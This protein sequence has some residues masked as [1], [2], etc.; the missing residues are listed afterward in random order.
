[1]I[2]IMLMLVAAMASA[3]SARDLN[4]KLQNRPY[5]DLRKWHL[6][7]SIG[8][9]TGGLNFTH[10]GFITDDGAQWRLEQP[11]YQPGFSVNGLVDLRLNNY[12]SLRFSPGMY[13]GS[14]DLKMADYNNPENTERQNI[15]TAMVVMPFDLKY[16][17]MRYRNARPYVIGGVMPA[18]DVSKRRSD[19]IKLKSSDVYLSVGFGCDFYLPYFKFIPEV[20]FCFGLSDLL[21]RDRPDLEDNPAA[22]VF[23]KSLSKIT[24]K[25]IVFTFYFE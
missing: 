2:L 10:N 13:F 1:I 17:A 18:F 9:Y 24:S 11:D 21:V 4:D 7:F 22:Q 5:A 23:T 12:F 25:M 15:K 14:Y 19:F 16:A 8:T 3:A 6:G 20:K